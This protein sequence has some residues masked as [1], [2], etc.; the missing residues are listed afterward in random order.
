MTEKPVF[1]INLGLSNE[2]ISREPIPVHDG[3]GEG[4]V[5]RQCR[6]DLEHLAED[7]VEVAGD[8]VL[9]VTDCLLSDLHLD[10]GV[11]LAVWVLGLKVNSL[12]TIN[13]YF[14]AIM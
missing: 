8:V 3:D 7:W 6:W 2:V 5:E 1:Q 14:V 9:F 10:V 13:I 11:R 4:V 12:K